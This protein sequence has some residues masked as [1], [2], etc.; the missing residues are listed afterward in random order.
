MVDSPE[1][2][3]ALVEAALLPDVDGVLVDQFKSY[4]AIVE[5]HGRAALKLG[6][7]TPRSRPQDEV[8][9]GLL[10]L[11]EQRLANQT[12]MDLAASFSRVANVSCDVP[13]MRLRFA[14]GSR[15]LSSWSLWAVTGKVRVP[16]VP[17]FRPRTAA[18]TGFGM[19]GLAS[20]TSIWA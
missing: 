3:S 4:T 17:G 18:S 15:C 7:N 10:A 9:V 6:K 16:T 14:D 1:S 8:S 19:D 20:R 2:A 11:A 12:L 13:S 5:A